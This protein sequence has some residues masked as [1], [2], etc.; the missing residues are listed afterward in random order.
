MSLAVPFACRRAVFALL[1]CPAALA[2]DDWPRF[3][4]PNGTGIASAPGLPVEWTAA[5]HAWETLLPGIGHSSPVVRDGRL[6]VTAANEDGTARQLVCLDA[7]DGKILWTR[8]LSLRTDT[9]HAKNSH[10]SGTPAV[11]DEFAVVAFADDERHV[12]AAYRLDGT[13]AWSQD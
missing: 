5:D 1:L 13:P 6:F 9:L 3:R 2:A 12:V 10:A 11:S 7:T 8:A 4:G